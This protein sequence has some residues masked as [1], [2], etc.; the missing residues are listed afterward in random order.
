MAAISARGKRSL[1][2]FISASLSGIIA[3]PNANKNITTG[4]LSI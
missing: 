1:K 4:V 3:I 2:S